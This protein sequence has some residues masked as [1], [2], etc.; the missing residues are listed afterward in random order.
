MA[1][2]KNN[3]VTRSN[4][5]KTATS[6]SDTEQTVAT[7]NPITI[8]NTI[9]ATDNTKTN[10]G[11]STMTRNYKATIGS[12]LAPMVSSHKSNAKNGT[13]IQ[14]LDGSEFIYNGENVAK[15][16]AEHQI[17]KIG[18]VST[19]D[20]YWDEY[21]FDSLEAYEDA[22]EQ[23]QTKI[24]DGDEYLTLDEGAVLKRLIVS[25]NLFPNSTSIIAGWDWSNP[26]LRID[27][28][29]LKG[30]EQG[31]VMNEL[32]QSFGDEHEFFFLDG[33]GGLKYSYYGGI[34]LMKKGVFIKNKHRDKVLWL[35]CDE[36]RVAELATQIKEAFNEGT[37]GKATA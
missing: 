1:A 6:T 37:K 18:K 23:L 9:H 19:N 4:V 17:V 32:Y 29:S 5:T 10:T 14:F 26:F 2:Q 24:F 13:S 30:D 3:V 22:V 31:N 20:P 7:T 35:P 12:L 36:S 34:Q 25:I 33:I 28:S 21:R 11:D 8:P 16:I 15:F 27:V